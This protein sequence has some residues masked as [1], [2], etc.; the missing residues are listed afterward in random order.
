MRL[1]PDKFRDSGFDLELVESSGD[2]RIYRQ[3]KKS[4]TIAFEVVRIRVVGS[5][6]LPSGTH[7]PKREAYPK[8]S[9]WG[10]SAFSCASIERARE[11][12]QEM[13]AK[14]SKAPGNAQNGCG[15][16]S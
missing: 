14:P 13:L 3:S 7:L 11:K 1:L 2:W 5:C 12:L 16:E 9:E 15:F 8:P 4:R 10:T 6:R